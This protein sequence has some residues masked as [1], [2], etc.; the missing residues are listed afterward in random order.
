M[1]QH[2]LLE[3]S[4]NHAEQARY[5]AAAAVKDLQHGKRWSAEVAM[6]LAAMERHLAYEK[7]D[8]HEIA[9]VALNECWAGKRAALKYTSP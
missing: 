3:E 9:W 7:W 2:S 8:T 6:D 1:S 5:Y 4:L